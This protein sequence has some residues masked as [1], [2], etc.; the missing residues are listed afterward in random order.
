ME[1]EGGMDGDDGVVPER[2]G[3]TIAIQ[4]NW[5]EGSGVDAVRYLPDATLFLKTLEEAQE[6]AVAIILV[7][8]LTRLFESKK[9]RGLGE[10]GER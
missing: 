4:R 2:G 10:L 3:N 7:I 8:T 5:G 1:F 9:R 6:R